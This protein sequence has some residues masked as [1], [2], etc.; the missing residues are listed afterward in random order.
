MIAVIFIAFFIVIGVL[1]CWQ[2][3]KVQTERYMES[4][5]ISQEDLAKAHKQAEIDRNWQNRAKVIRPRR[6][7][8]ELDEHEPLT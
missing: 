8:S 2:I 5:R 4:Q 7:C 3:Y 1:L 6:M